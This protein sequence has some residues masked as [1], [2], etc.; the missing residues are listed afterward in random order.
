VPTLSASPRV[1]PTEQTYSVATLRLGLFSHQLNHGHLHQLV[2]SANR[3]KVVDQ[4]SNSSGLR[5]VAERDKGIA[6]TCRVGF[7]IISSPV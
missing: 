5:D 4:V 1:A 3:V 6:L 2:H 7:L